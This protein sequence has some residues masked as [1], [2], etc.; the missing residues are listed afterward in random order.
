VYAA[1]VVFTVVAGAL[2]IVLPR[3]LA[4][5]PLLLAVAYT[6]RNPVLEVGPANLSCLRILVV[7]GIVR[8]LTRGERMANGVNGVDGLLLGWAVLLIGSSVFHTPDAWT[9]RLGIVLGEVGLY[10]LCRVF[11]QDAEDVRRIFMIVCLALAP[12][13]VLMLLEKYT[14]HNYFGPMGTGVL[15]MRDGHVRAYGPFGHPILAG[16]VGATCVPMALC[17]WRAHRASALIGLCAA[18]GIVFASTS[19]GPIMMVV[20]T[21]AGLLIWKVRNRMGLIRWGTVGVIIAL[22]LV[23]NDPVYFLMA[24]IDIT[25]SS[26]GWHR[27]QLIRSSLA[28]LGEWWAVG[29]DYTRHWMPTGIYANDN[30]T[31]IT[32]HFLQM[33]IMGGLPL[34]ILFVLMVWAAFRAVGIALRENEARL[35]ERGFLIWTLGAMLFGQVINFWSIS[36]FDQSIFFFYLVLAMIGAVQLTVAPVCHQS[37]PSGARQTKRERMATSSPAPAG[38]ARKGGAVARPGRAFPVVERWPR[39]SISTAPGGKWRRSQTERH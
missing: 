11:L 23:M 13:A 38:A 12:L 1:P 5:I 18:A 29:T 37:L 30:H 25:G 31:D 26:T 19:S 2:I 6:A 20:F 10:F 3:R 34:L 15:L 16:T 28:H 21:C 8:V 7:I 9:F 17:L 24:R 22:Q 36:L 39:T 4:L 33:G 27:S 35:G 14:A 32:N